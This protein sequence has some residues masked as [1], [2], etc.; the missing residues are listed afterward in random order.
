MSRGKRA[1]DTH[2]EDND[3]D[4]LPVE[5]VRLDKWLWAARFYKTRALAAEAID[6]GKADVNGERA[7]RAKPVQ[8]GDEVRLRQGPIEWCLKILDVS[9]RR[10]SAEIARQL[11]EETEDGR[12]RRERVSEHLRSMPTG[13]AYGDSKPGKRDRRAL[14]RLKGDG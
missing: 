1:P 11:Y 4:G 8:A 14:R 3:N 7:K 6:G 2:D 12:V 9:A 13:F 10:G 5:R